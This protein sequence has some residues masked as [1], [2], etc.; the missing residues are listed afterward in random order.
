ML[1][2]SLFPKSILSASLTGSTK[3]TKPLRTLFRDTLMA[4]VPFLLASHSHGRANYYQLVLEQM[5]WDEA[6]VACA[7]RGGNLATITSE[8]EWDVVYNQLG[9]ALAGLDIWLGGRRVSKEDDNWYWITGEPWGAPRA[10]YQ[11][12]RP[13]EPDGNYGEQ[14]CLFIN[15]SHGTHG[16]DLLWNDHPNNY[17]EQAF[18]RYIIKGY[19]AEFGWA[20][21]SGTVVYEGNKSG[22]IRLVLTGGPQDEPGGTLEFDSPSDFFFHEVLVGWD[23]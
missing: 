14:D 15:G 22:K 8:E 11:R 1:F 13:A 4:V 16:P 2:G 3:P 20:S 6:V 23:Y 19:I 18:S 7:E 9:S 10:A 5:S 17:D 12:W 21:M